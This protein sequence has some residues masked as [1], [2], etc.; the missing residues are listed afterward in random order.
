MLPADCELIMGIREINLRT[1][2]LLT[3]LIAS[4]LQAADI[5]VATDG[6]DRWSGTL[7]R[8]NASATDGPVATLRTA[9]EITRQARARSPQATPR[10][11]VEGGSYFLD[12]PLLLTAADSGLAIEAAPGEGPVLYGGRRI[13]GWQREGEHFWSV[14]LPGVRER[15]WDFR[16]LV[17]DGEVRPRARLPRTGTF[18]HLSEFKVRWMGTT[19]GGWQRKPTHEELT[20]L[21]YRPEDIGTWLDTNNAELTVYHMW[22]VSSVGVAANDASTHTLTFSSEAGHPPGAFGVQKYVVW[23]IREGMTKPGQW[24]LDR[25]AGKLVYWPFPGEDMERAEVIAPTME[26]LIHLQGTRDAPVENVTLE[27]LTLAVTTTPL[28]AGGFGAGEY[29]GVVSLVNTRECR[30][31]HLTILNAAGQGIKARASERLKIEGAEIHDVGAC[32][33]LAGG[34][35]MFISNNLVQHIGILYPSALG[36]LVEGPRAEIS[37]NE[38]HDT[39][40]SA[41]DAGGDDTRLE[42]N[43]IYNAMQVLHDGAGIYAGFSKRIVMRGNVV[44]DI[45]DTGGYGSSA[46]Y[47]DEQ[48]DD[49]LVEGN[50]AL[51]VARPA[52]NHWAHHGTYRGNVFLVEGNA[53]I[54]FPRSHAFTLER[55]VI[56]ATGTVTFKAPPDGLEAM[57]DNV[58]FSGKGQVE[59]V[60][61]NDYAEAAREPLQPR[62][63]SIFADPLFVD[64]QHGDYRFRPDSPALKLGI[65]KLDVSGAGRL[66]MP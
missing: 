50:L 52:H 43:L 64:W 57:P 60:T 12:Q 20:T 37:H 36:M 39:P 1:P 66:P 35:G 7:A 32:G 54:D 26:S 38:I 23:N 2:L 16:L 65:P 11:V 31:E 15:Q 19:G 51:R 42:S 22:D 63:G 48:G 14:A 49:F 44:R 21:R 17:V 8:P 58:I 9:L 28:K 3:L 29:D 46:Y 62:D 27:G 61:Y 55:N 41:I 34:P 45:V 53:T 5:Y 30:L 13:T 18:M 56:Y 33:I 25:T 24:Y 40:Y 10:I 47:I 59:S 6:S 4:S